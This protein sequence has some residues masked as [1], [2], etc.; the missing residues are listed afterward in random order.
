MKG[1]IQ[2]LEQV[3]R[4]FIRKISGVQNLSYWK[5]LQELSM[6]S[7]ERRRERY[8]I[9]YVWRIMEKQVPNFCRPDIG[10]I[11]TAWHPR[12]GRICRVPTLNLRGPKQFQNVRE[13]SFGVKGPR[14]FN[15]LPAHIRKLSGCSLDIFKNSLDKYLATVPDEPQIIGYTAMRRADTNS[16]LHMIQHASAHH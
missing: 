7:L 16:L 6:Y 4:S 11:Q 3:Q 9:L 15:I 13:T 1:D 10:G 12:R 5:Q 8:M 2:K 14:L